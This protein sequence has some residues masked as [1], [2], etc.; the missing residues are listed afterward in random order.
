[1]KPE[2]RREEREGHEARLRQA[3]SGPGL[4]ARIREDDDLVELV[5]GQSGG[6]VRLGDLPL[7]AT[8]DE[9][10]RALGEATGADASPAQRLQSARERLAAV[11]PTLL[12][13]LTSARLGVRIGRLPIVRGQ[14]DVVASEPVVSPTA[15]PT[16]RFAL[17]SIPR[18]GDLIRENHGFGYHYHYSDDGRRRADILLTFSRTQQRRS[19]PAVTW[20]PHA[21]SKAD[22]QARVNA[23]VEDKRASVQSACQNDWRGRAL[24]DYVRPGKSHAILMPEG[25]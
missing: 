25:A 12:E 17:V 23:W 3:R 6:G 14:L 4:S 9:L 18:Y 8:A 22:F 10:E 15:T 7:A 2:R 21:V 11:H 19:H 5:L 16:L 24:D 1:M 20:E 13:A